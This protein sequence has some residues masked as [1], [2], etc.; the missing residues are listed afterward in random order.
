MQTF[1]KMGNGSAVSGMTLLKC[2]FICTLYL[3]MKL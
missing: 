1:V 2:G 3:L